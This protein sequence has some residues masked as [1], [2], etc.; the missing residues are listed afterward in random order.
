MAR[1]SPTPGSEIRYSDILSKMGLSLSNRSLD[2]IEVTAMGGA[3]QANASAANSLCMPYQ[4][5]AI[6]SLGNGG[7]GAPGANWTHLAGI[8]N[9][10]PARISEFRNAYNAK[11][12]I[13]ASTQTTLNR[14]S[15]GLTVTG[16]N[17]D[18]GGPYY[19]WVET[20]L[21][22]A[23]GF[24]DWQQGNPN[25]KAYSVTGLASGTATFVIWIQDVEGCGNRKD[26]R[27]N[28]DIQYP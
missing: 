6:S 5:E 12:V 14:D 3:S 16:S 8:T 10:R 19:F 15:C 2:A 22:S 7:V 17:S 25:S 11:P 18:A 23:T 4:R 1:I 27:R 21:G 9:W 28:P 26:I 24:G 20:N 13:S